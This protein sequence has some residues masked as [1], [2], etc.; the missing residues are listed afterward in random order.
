[1]SFLRT[2]LF[3]AVVSLLATFAT[4]AAFAQLDVACPEDA[5][6]LARAEKTVREAR[7][8]PSDVAL[9]YSYQLQPVPTLLHP[10]HQ[11]TLT[12]DYLGCC[13]MLCRIIRADDGGKIIVITP[14]GITERSL[15]REEADSLVREFLYLAR[16]TVFDEVGRRLRGTSGTFSTHMPYVRVVLGGSAA[17]DLDVE[18]VLGPVQAE[19]FEA[20]IF[21]PGDSHRFAIEW[22]LFEISR[23]IREQGPPVLPEPAVRDEWLTILRESPPLA[24]VLRKEDHL[25][26]RNILAALAARLMVTWGVREALPELVR[27][28]LEEESTWLDLMT[29][30]DPEERLVLGLGHW[31]ERLLDYMRDHPSRVSAATRRRILLR[32]V[33]ACPHPGLLPSI[34]DDLIEIGMSA[35]ELEPV[36]GWASD[37]AISVEIR[38]QLLRLLAFCADDPWARDELEEIASQ[39]PSMAAECRAR[40]AAYLARSVG[41][42][43]DAAWRARA[44]RLLRDLLAISTGDEQEGQACETIADA[45]GAVG[46]EQDIDLLFDLGRRQGGDGC[47]HAI[48]LIDPGQGLR[49]AEESARYH[50]DPTNRANPANA[51]SAF[52]IL[53]A[54]DDP[55]GLALLEELA[56]VPVVSFHH[57][58][59][60]A[61]L[62]RQLGES[63][64]DRRAAAAIE[65]FA[66]VPRE[67]H[68]LLEAR[69]VRRGASDESLRPLREW[70]SSRAWPYGKQF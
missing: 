31:G 47:F 43:G 27:L 18:R 66:W 46:E 25:D 12:S 68:G 42:E 67:L 20:P 49:A 21:S 26:E 13:P 33:G 65:N 44:R 38:I 4:P 59:S 56:R 29:C 17:T 35:D 16:I 51:S 55:A 41:G 30:D 22:L 61:A 57:A 6:A 19:S 62:R 24:D 3:P 34:V 70:R 32:A 69:L 48:C 63:D 7:R 52:G 5:A 53:C 64:P 28:G 14:D 45:L 50:L 37:P 39:G 9:R 2:E 15:P 54:I 11:L 8:H 58:E 36:R 60:I 40:A 10:E 23:R 1:M